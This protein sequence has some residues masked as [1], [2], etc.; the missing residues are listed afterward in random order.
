MT[1]EEQIN[2]DMKNAMKSK[3]ESRLSCIRFLKAAIKNRQV[4]KRDKLDDDEICS[5][6]SSLIRRATDSV[7]EFRQGGREDLAAKEEKEIEIMSRYL[8]KQLSTEEIEAILSETVSELSARGPKDLG[9]VMKAAMVKM[10]GRA[11]G[12][13]VNEIAKRLL[14]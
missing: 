4:E 1:L 7:K 8:P 12:R 2:E 13:E 11:Q 9:K 14:G 6:I 3:D 10:A 5:I